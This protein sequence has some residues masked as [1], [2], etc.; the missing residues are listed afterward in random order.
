MIRFN[1]SQHTLLRILG[2]GHCHSGSELGQALGITRSAIWKQIKQ[3]I[4]LGIPIHSIPQQGYRFAHEFMFLDEECIVQELK[5]QQCG[6]PFK[7]HVFSSIHSTNRYLKE[8]PSNSALDICCAEVQTQG[9]GRFG[10]Y[11]HSP[12]G[13]NIYCSSRWSLD[14]DLAKLSGLSLVCSLAVLATIQALH[15]SP[16]SKIKWPND[17]LWHD[18]KLCG[19]LIEINAES[20][21]Q[22][23]IIIGIG[24]NVNSDTQN[25]PLNDTDLLSNRPWCSLYELTQK[26][27]NRNK[28]I[29]SLIVNL[30]RYLN[31]FIKH[32]LSVFLDEW[33]QHD[34][35]YG[36]EIRVNQLLETLSGI[37]RGINQAGQLIVEDQQGIRHLLS[38][39]DTSLKSMN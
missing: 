28:L 8:L 33:Q 29:A 7:L 12:F 14:C 25:N 24:L 10:R 6:T 20:N 21:G 30:E 36:Q 15:P 35:L 5:T 16:H 27:H 26:Y 13:E 39:G 11:W 2:D 31:R 23:Q 9:K 38:S 4:D 17:I 19:S 34:Y 32:D 3:L 1:P 37:A 18:K 22:S